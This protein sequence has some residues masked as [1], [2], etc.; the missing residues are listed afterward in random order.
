MMERW[1]QVGVG[2]GNGWPAPRLLL[3][4]GSW[5]TDAGRGTALG[6]MA[7]AAAEAGWAEARGRFRA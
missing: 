6:D 1:R 2:G 3:V 5:D 4:W 7:E